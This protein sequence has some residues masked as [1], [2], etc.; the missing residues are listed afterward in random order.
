LNP[1][2]SQNGE[3]GLK[4]WKTLKAISDLTP[5]QNQACAVFPEKDLNIIAY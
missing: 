4:P 2:H 5:E 1:T 3:F